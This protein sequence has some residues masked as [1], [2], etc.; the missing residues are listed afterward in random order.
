MNKTTNTAARVLQRMEQLKSEFTTT[1]TRP[2]ARVSVKDGSVEIFQREKSSESLGERIANH[3][4]RHSQRANAVKLV[5]AVLKDVESILAPAAREDRGIQ[6]EL[7]KERVYLRSPRHTNN[8]MLKTIA[9]LETLLK[10]NIMEPTPRR[11]STRAPKTVRPR[12]QTR[13]AKATRP[14]WAGK[15]PSAVAGRVTDRPVLSKTTPPKMTKRPVAPSGRTAVATAMPSRD[16]AVPASSSGK[17]KPVT[18]LRTAATDLASQWQAVSTFAAK[19]NELDWA[20]F[21]SP[22]LTPSFSDFERADQGH[23]YKS[24]ME[25]TKAGVQAFQKFLRKVD[26]MTPEGINAEWKKLNVKGKK[27]AKDDEF[28]AAEKMGILRFASQL[29]ANPTSVAPFPWVPGVLA[30]AKIVVAEPAP[31]STRAP[32]PVRQ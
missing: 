10:A 24:G 19:N 14:E 2:R 27:S 17:A 4:A 5:E 9:S 6:S 21:L 1:D 22:V 3:L 7:D 30:I 15:G 12:L 29:A 23:A 31:P 32:R 16:A 18:P 20:E 13:T 28:T 11:A 26:G 25:M 8:G